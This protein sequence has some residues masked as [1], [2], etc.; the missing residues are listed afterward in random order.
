MDPHSIWLTFIFHV[1]PVAIVNDKEVVEVDLPFSKYTKILQKS[2]R[3]K[4]TRW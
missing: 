1:P 3:I 2:S 4:G